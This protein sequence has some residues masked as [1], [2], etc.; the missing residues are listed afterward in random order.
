M[1]IDAL[2]LSSLA[3]RSY[4]VAWQTQ[5]RPDAQGV[6][7]PTKVPFNPNKAGAEA[8]ANEAS[9]WGTRAAAEQCAQALPKPYGIG[10]VGLELAPLGDGRSLAGID[11][12]TCRDKETGKLEGWAEDVIADYDT[13]TEIS[14]SETGVKTFFSYDT[15]ALPRLRTFMGTAAYSKIYQ[16]GSGEHPPAIELH[17]GNRYFAVTDEALPN[18]SLDLRHVDASTILRLIQHTGPA[19]KKA[20]QDGSAKSNRDIFGRDASRSVAAFKIGTRAVQNGATFDQMC[21]A[22]RADPSTADWMREK[23]EANNLREARRIFDKAQAAGPVIRI[24]GGDLHKTASAGEAAIIMDGRPIYQRGNALVRPVVQEVPAA[25]G[26]MTV[27]A[28][29]NEITATGLVDALCGC[30]IW[31]RFDARAEDWVRINPPK[32]VAEIILSR[33]GLWTFP[34]IV[35]VVTCPTL[36]PDG[37]ILSAPGYDPS[38][39]LY[40]AADTTLRLTDAVHRPTKAAADDA[41]TDLSR[42][43][44]EFPFV[45]ETSRSVAL[46][47]LITPVVRG[48]LTVA[49][50]HAF[51]A[52]TAGT[53]KSY[54]V[55]TASAISTGRPCPVAAAAAD[56]AETEKRIAGLLLGGFPIASLDNVNGELGGDLLCQAIERPLIRIRRLGASDIVEIESRATL[57]ATGNALRVRGDMTRRTVV[58]DLDA[59]LERPEL[60]LFQFDPVAAVMANR[61][62]YVSAHAWSLSGP[63]SPPAALML[64]RRWVASPTGRRWCGPLWSGLAAPTQRTAWKRRGKTTLSWQSC[65]SS[66]SPGRVAYLSLR[67]TR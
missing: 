27:S 55:D 44:S 67:G 10:G 46:S 2:T 38:T 56:E 36:R 65:G 24:I 35:G 37:S 63:T 30:A 52:N 20:A 45:N 26:Q 15:A 28:A 47:G 66:W 9:T 7:K 49:P 34:K 64:S 4:W 1:S 58:A 41:L 11:L 13:Y 60:R 12:D 22:L 19:F 39:R 50:L 57:F 21:E 43:L 33:A 42:L 48:A 40:H 59:G 3:P 54:L 17:L 8:R 53:G 14:P 18:A 32:Q 51:R 29:L 16:R 62:R 23:G 5:D 6:N 31:E 61:S 25:R